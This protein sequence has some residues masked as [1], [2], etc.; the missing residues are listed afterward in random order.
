MD[1]IIETAVQHYMWQST[2]MDAGSHTVM[3][4]M[5]A[6]GSFDWQQHTTSPYWMDVNNKFYLIFTAV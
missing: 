5:I 3:I 1:L 6:E 2:V 4:F